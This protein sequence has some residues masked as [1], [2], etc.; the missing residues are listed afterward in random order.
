MKKYKS[1][2]DVILLIGLSVISFFA[3]AEDSIT[4]PS[5]MQMALLAIVLALLAAFLT[6]LWRENPRDEREAQNQALASRLAYIIGSIVLIVALVTQSLQHELDAAVPV[7][8]FAML[9]TKLL[10]QRFK[11]GE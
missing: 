5:S 4:M 6:L 8:L 10:V 3:V 1:L 7:T 9:A 2:S 11:D